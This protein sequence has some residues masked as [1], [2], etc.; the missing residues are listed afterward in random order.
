MMLLLPE[1][2]YV[3]EQAFFKAVFQ[4]P[5]AG[6]LTRHGSTVRRDDFIY[7][8]TYLPLLSAS[9][10]V[11]FTVGTGTVLG[12]KATQD[13]F[14]YTDFGAIELLERE[15]CDIGAGVPKLEVVG[16]AVRRPD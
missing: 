4:T 1:E 9:G 3:L 10:E 14:G 8:T 15:V 12:G 6:Q 13:Q 2:E 16:P 7:R 5:C 11:R